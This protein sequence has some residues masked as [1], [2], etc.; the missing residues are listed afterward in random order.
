MLETILIFLEVIVCIA[1]IAAV[2]LQ[3]G[4]G[5]GVSST[6]G[7]GDGAFFGKGNDLDSVMANATIVLGICFAVIT[8][9]LAKVNA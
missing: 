3:S 4:K 7:G 8:L 2:L 5:G 9:A 6:F 1:L